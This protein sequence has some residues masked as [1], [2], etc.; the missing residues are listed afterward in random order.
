MRCVIIGAGTY[1]EVY[2]TYLE[3]AGVDVVGFLDDNMN[4]IEDEDS[5]IPILGLTCDSDAV[6][7]DN[8]VKLVI[9]AVKSITIKS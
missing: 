7:K 8:N 2:L 6:I 1:G 5:T 3:E 4:N 9:I